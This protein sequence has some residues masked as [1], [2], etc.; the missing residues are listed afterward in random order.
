MPLVMR[1]NGKRSVMKRLGKEE[2]ALWERCTEG[3]AFEL[4]S[5]R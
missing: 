3:T 4:R 1:S 5:R 2:G